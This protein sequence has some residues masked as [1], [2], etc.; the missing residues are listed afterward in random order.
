MSGNITNKTV[1]LK[2]GESIYPRI[3]GTRYR[4]CFG[5][6]CRGRLSIILISFFLVLFFGS[7]CLS[8]NAE[9][10]RMTKRDKPFSVYF[11]DEKC[12]WTVGD[13]G[14]ALKTADG[15]ENWERVKI[16]DE[17]F[18]DVFFVGEKGWIVGSDRLILHTDDGGKSWKKQLESIR[19]PPAEGATEV[20][21]MACPGVES[22]GK[23]LMKV[24][25]FDQNRGISVGVDGTILRTNNGGTSWEDVSLDCMMILPEEVMMKGIISINLY[26]ILFTDENS[27]WIVGDSGA[28]L[29]SE[30]GGKQWSLKNIGLLP[31]LFSVSFKNDKVGWAVGQNGFSLKTMDGGKTWE[32]VVIEKEHSL[33]EITLSDNY[34]VIVGDQATIL[35]TND[36]GDSWEKVETH[37]Q[38]PFP[39]ISGAVILPSNSAKVLSVG[40]GIILETEISTK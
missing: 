1:I 4:K 11:I 20:N 22:S 15:G 7:T 14:L 2:V 8:S 38:P 21:L 9:G 6:Y 16:S 40:K 31:S 17:I 39:W 3:K 25:F 12:G 5:K 18:N 24:A 10:Y 23:S 34:G 32:K 13:K 36:G 27:C 33:Y 29:H 30:D 19:R 35:K 37:L 26:D 28:V